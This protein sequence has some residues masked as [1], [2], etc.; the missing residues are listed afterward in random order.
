VVTPVIAAGAGLIV[1]IAVAKQPVGK[2]YDITEVPAVT[3][4]ITPVVNPADELELLLDQ[5]PPLLASVS[6]ADNPTHNVPAPDIAAGLGLTVIIAVWVHPVEFNV[7]VTTAVPA[8]M[9]VRIPEVEPI[10]ATAVLL[11]VH[12]PAPVASVRVALL[13]THIV[14]EPDTAATALTVTVVVPI[15]AQLVLAV[16]VNT[17]G[18]VAVT[19]LATGL[20]IVVLFKKVAGLQE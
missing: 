3:A 16:A 14:V 15:A 19:E 17:Y 12:V 4:M 9:P 20:A 7:N 8:E 5:N 2:V 11:L 13:P 10:V 1:S 18:V 6:V